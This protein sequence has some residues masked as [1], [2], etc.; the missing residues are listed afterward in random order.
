MD[1]ITD[2]PEVKGY[3]KIW[4][5]VDRFSKMTHF[6]LLKKITVQELAIAFINHVWRLHGLPWSIV[7]DWDPIF[8]RRFCSAILKI[9]NIRADLSTA[10]HPQTDGQTE[11]VNQILE[12]YLRCYCNWDQSDWVD[13]LLLAEFCY[14][15]SKHSATKRTPF[16]ATYRRNPRSSSLV[17]KKDIKSDA[18]KE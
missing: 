11:R 17:A 13:L 1:F 12:Y 15:N 10:Y 7:S 6:I 14:N 16:E 2:L 9:S 4:V 3:Y 5:I 8:T 18:A